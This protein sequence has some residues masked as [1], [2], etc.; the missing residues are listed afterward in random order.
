[1]APVTRAVSA[2]EQLTEGVHY[3]RTLAPVTR[4]LLTSRSLQCGGG[5]QRRRPLPAPARSVQR[6]PGRWVAD[7]RATAVVL[8]VTRMTMKRGE[9][10]GKMSGG[11]G[12]GAGS[13]AIF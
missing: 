11:G 6:K 2:V 7:A 10:M 3:S 12:G 9:R 8:C 4:H 13:T 1:M 5:Q